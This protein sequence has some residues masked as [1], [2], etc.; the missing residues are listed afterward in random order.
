[1]EKEW[2]ENLQKQAVTNREEIARL[3]AE[4]THVTELKS[5]LKQLQREND[6]LRRSCSEQ[7]TVSH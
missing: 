7:E 6:D 1:M 2:R 5:A 4:V 3:R